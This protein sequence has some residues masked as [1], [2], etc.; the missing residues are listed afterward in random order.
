MSRVTATVDD[1]ATPGPEDW[2]PTSTTN[3]DAKERADFLASWGSDDKP[4]RPAADEPDDGDGD[5]DD[6]PDDIEDEDIEEVAPAKAPVKK[7]KAA[8]VEPIEEPDDDSDLDEDAPDED[9]DKPDPVVAKGMA[10]L[11]KQEQRM[12]AQWT[13]KETRWQAEQTK[14]REDLTAEKA[15]AAEAKAELAKLRARVKADPAGVLEDLGVDDWDFTAKMAFVRSTAGAKP[16]NKEA[17]ARLQAERE[18]KAKLSDVEKKLAARE[19]AE[20]DGKKEAEV[21]GQVETYLGTVAK[22]AAAVKSA[23]LTQKMLAADPNYANAQISA[24]A[25]KLYKGGEFPSVRAVIVEVEKQERAM[26]RRYGINPKTLA[27]SPA[28]AAG[29]PVKGKNGKAAKVADDD[30]LKVPSREELLGEDWTR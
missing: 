3:A 11:Q 18:M 28:A 4:G 30:D 9:E 7:A 25:H 1:A 10:K 24:A 12:R 26:L 20:E 2:R 23:T 8:P 15:A 29:K 16:E 27:A 6:A 21:R 22:A 19:K 13:E 14:A 5:L 17:A